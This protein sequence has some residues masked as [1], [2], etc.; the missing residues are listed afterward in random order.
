MSSE[1][2]HYEASQLGHGSGQKI[3]TSVSHQHQGS[4]GGAGLCDESIVKDD[5]WIKVLIVDRG[6]SSLLKT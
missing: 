3:N 1:G 6:T 2:S 5:N 4:G